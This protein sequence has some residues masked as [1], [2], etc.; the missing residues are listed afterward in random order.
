MRCEALE[1][2]GRC[3]R[4]SDVAAAEKIFEAALAV[5]EEHQLS[6]W[7]ARALHEL[8][9]IDLFD[10][11]STDR[12]V[13]SRRAAVEAGAPALAAVADFHLASALVARNS[14]ADGRAAAQRAV[15]VATR[16]RLSVLAPALTVLARSYAHERD[17]D[18]VEAVVARVREAAPDDP[19]AE[20]AVQS[21]VYSMLALHDADLA[22][23]RQ[24]LDRAADLL[25][26]CPGLHD[27]HRGLWALLCTLDVGRPDGG[28]AQR[29][30]AAASAG[31][32]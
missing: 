15:E 22:A 27:P 19:A 9:T 32:D 12:L 25:R 24:A 17:R 16:L 23:A 29:A 21:H 18:T 10:R 2:L 3:R 14:L 7:R 6:L 26:S 11:M 1:V 30:E 4:L 5:A 28:A 13:A 8:G 20:A 31:S